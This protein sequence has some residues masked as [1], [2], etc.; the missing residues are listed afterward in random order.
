MID[1]D[2][3]RNSSLLKWAQNN[4][5]NKQGSVK[6]KDEKGKKYNCPKISNL[7]YF[8]PKYIRLH[9]NFKKRYHKNNQYFSFKGNKNW[10]HNPETLKNGHVAYLVKV[11]LFH[12][13]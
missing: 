12:T 4:K 13:L 1:Q 6:S 7:I 3:M 11:S 5:T 9:N 2:K 10:I 8:T